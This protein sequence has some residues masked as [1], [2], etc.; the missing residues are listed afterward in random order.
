ML[1]PNILRNG[2]LLG[3]S[4]VQHIRSISSTP[5]LH[6]RRELKVVKLM[7]FHYR[8]PLDWLRNK[9]QTHTVR[10]K[11]D[12]DFDLNEFLHGSVQACSTVTSVLAGQDANLLN[13]MLT[14]KALAMVQNSMQKYST[15]EIT[16]LACAPEHVHF[17][18]PKNI[19]VIMLKDK[20]YLDIDV[21]FL[22]LK[23]Y[24]DDSDKEANAKITRIMTEVVMRFSRQYTET[25][26][27]WFIT[28]A[29]VVKHTIG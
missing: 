15:A 11:L 10:A 1:F 14:P 25:V 23:A 9:Y 8:S 4:A 13:G 2:R 19:A 22:I 24:I 17:A 3:A 21:F 29:K 12:P 28:K 26:T 5:V 20:R 7:T 27:D 18:R 6:C 16:E